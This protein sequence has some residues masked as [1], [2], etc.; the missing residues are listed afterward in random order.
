[1]LDFIVLGQVPGTGIEVSFVLAVIGLLA[2]LTII[3]GYLL[4]KRLWA[5]AV[6]TART[7]LQLEF[8]SL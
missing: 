8:I 5:Q 4:I 7:L 2:V 1:M 6:L 3:L